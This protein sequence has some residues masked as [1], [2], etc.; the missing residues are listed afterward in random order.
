MQ[1]IF[2]IIYHFICGCTFAIKTGVHYLALVPSHLSQYVNSIQRFIEVI[3]S[4][5]GGITAFGVVS[6]I[7]LAF[8]GR[9]K[10]GTL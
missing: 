9:G 7:A 6:A 5:W 2:E 1:D 10:G 8:M 4:P 3:P